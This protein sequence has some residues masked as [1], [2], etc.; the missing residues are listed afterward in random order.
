MVDLEAPLAGSAD[1]RKRM[2]SI[3]SSLG[4]TGLSDI[5]PSGVRYSRSSV[6]FGKMFEPGRG[7][8]ASPQTGEGYLVLLSKVGVSQGMANIILGLHMLLQ[9]RNF[10]SHGPVW[11]SLRASS[12]QWT[13]R[14]HARQ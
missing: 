3:E 12:E 8:E 2:R 6:A 11:Q 13:G 4:V 5:L 14:L 9:T 10:A 7:P 1:A